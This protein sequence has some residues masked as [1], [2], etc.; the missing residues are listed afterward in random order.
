MAYDLSTAIIGEAIF[1]L[2]GLACYCHD[3]LHTAAEQ[4][5]TMYESSA[6]S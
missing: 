2:P 6:V 5:C 4:G 1:F 3:V